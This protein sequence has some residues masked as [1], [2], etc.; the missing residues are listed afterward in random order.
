MGMV[1]YLNST[2]FAANNW[3]AANGLFCLRFEEAA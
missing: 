3:L 1:D 2:A